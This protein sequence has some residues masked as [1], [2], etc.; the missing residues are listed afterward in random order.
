MKYNPHKYQK[1]TQEFI[2]NNPICGL[3]LDMGLGKTI[4]TL[5]AIWSLLLDYFDVGKVLIIAPLRVAKDTWPK[6]VGKWDHLKGLTISIVV[7]SK[8][9]REKA[10]KKK[11]N[12]YI[13]NRENVEWLI[14][15][16]KWDF[17]MIVVDELSSFKSSSSKRFKALRKVRPK[18][19]RI[20]GLT[21]TPTPNGL[22][23]LWPQINLLDMGERLGRFISGYRERYF[24]A[25]KRNRDVIFSYKPKEGAKEA[26][27]EKISDICISMKAIDYLDMPEC[28]INK[29]EVCMNEK[30]I[31]YY[32]KL[33][34][35]MI[36]PFK[37]GDI[38]AVNAAALSNKLLQMANGGVYD[39]NG[40]V[41][42]IHDR[43]LDAL[44][45]LI[46]D[47]KIVSKPLV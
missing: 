32:R 18:V 39:E 45:D 23:D 2:V 14:N 37:D 3:F 21:G 16:Y 35:D 24:I 29:V 28:I 34:R 4:I 20:V 10:L 36:L 12:I 17:D 44:E 11:A 43:K 33:E 47:S 38:D 26:I 19:K 7:G 6:E 13:I 40:K 9:D 8:N 25:D 46:E 22:M 30:E 5:T 15:N 42:I 1:Y 41:K 31:K 27:Y